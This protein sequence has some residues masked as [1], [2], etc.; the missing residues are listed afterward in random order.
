MLLIWD[1][2]FSF[3]VWWNASSRTE[4]LNLFGFRT[5][6]NS[7]KLL[8]LPKSF[9]AKWL[10]SIHFHILEVKTEKLK[11]F[12]NSLNKDNILH[13]HFKYKNWWKKVIIVFYISA[14]L[15]KVW[16]NKRQL[17]SHICFYAR[18]AVILDIVKTQETYS[19][20]LSESEKASNSLALWEW[21]AVR[22]PGWG[23]SESWVYESHFGNCSNFPNFRGDKNF[24]N[25]QI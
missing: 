1:L 7:W 22:T 17:D 6:L 8:S 5:L 24:R 18:S 19:I 14:N 23:L 9:H 13:I 4:V 20:L 3:L 10:T 2:P 12:I 25:L 16:L 15:F 21:F 11:I